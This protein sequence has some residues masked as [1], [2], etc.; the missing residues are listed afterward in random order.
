MTCITRSFF[1]LLLLSHAG[2]PQLALSQ[3]STR[4]PLTRKQVV[5]RSDKPSVYLCVDGGPRQGKAGEDGDVLWLRIVNNTIWT[6]RF[7]ATRGGTEVRPLKLSNG[8]IVSGLTKKSAVDPH[9]QVEDARS[10][11]RRE[12][13]S[14]GDVGTVNFLPSDISALFS[15]PDRYLKEGALFVEYKYEWEFIGTVAEESN[16]PVHRI[17]LRVGDLSELSAYRC[18]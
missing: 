8:T 12:G 4:T 1:L 13:P 17:Y 18:D 14:L 2:F 15:V 7:K 9:Y 10:G 3:V 16:S 6:I 5:I 11:H